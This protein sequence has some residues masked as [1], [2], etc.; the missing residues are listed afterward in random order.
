M[1]NTF[2]ASNKEYNKTMTDEEKDLLR[3][4][5]TMRMEA[6]STLNQISLLLKRGYKL[7]KEINEVLDRIKWMDLLEEELKNKK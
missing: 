6:K 4:I 2:A 3:R 7:D 1:V 5:P